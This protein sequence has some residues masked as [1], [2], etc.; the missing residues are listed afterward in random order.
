MS[1]GYGRVGFVL[2]LAAAMVAATARLDAAEAQVVTGKVSTVT[3][4][5]GQALVQRTVPVEGAVGPVEVVVT[6]LPMH[7]VPDSLFAETGDGIDVRAVRYR[8]RAVGDEP[9]EAV[10]KLDEDIER[11]EDLVARTRRMQALL[12]K[13]EAYLDK[14]EN[15]IA[16]TMKVELAKGV[17]N[18]EQVEKLSTFSFDARQKDAEESLK[19]AKEERDL[20]KELSVLKRR[21]AEL[22]R[23]S[24]RTIREALLFLQKR[25]AGNAAV[26]LSYL[27]GSAGWT[28]AYN[29]RAAANRQSVAIEYN[30]IIRQQSGEDWKDVELVLSTATPALSSQGPG[31]APFRVALRKT[32]GRQ[33][34]RG[35]VAQ[36]YKNTQMS[37]N[38]AWVQMSNTAVSRSNLDYNWAMNK[39]GN[40]GQMCE[41]QADRDA[42]RVLK[43]E[44]P[45]ELGGAS[46]SYKLTGRTSVASRSDQQM[47]RISNTTLASKFY[48]VATPVLTGYVYREA[49]LKNTAADALLGGP[50]S[51]Y[52]NGR[53]V[54][55]AE[56]P[57][58][59]SG[60]IFIIGFGAD[61]QLRATRELVDKSE[62]VQGGNREITFQ[63]RLV[64]ENYKNT[65]V[66]VRLF[67]RVPVAE[68]EDDLRLT[69]GEMKDKISA[70]KL[71]LRTERPKG[72]LRWDVD[73][74]A[75]ASGEKA[76]I[77]A[78]DYKLAFD[79]SLELH[80]PTR[81]R[82]AAMQQEFFDM[83]RGRQKR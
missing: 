49:E 61:P 64:L 45:V 22:T 31:L 83:Q 74:L 48:H 67:D 11:V 76:R 25:R 9:R 46:I 47:I 60:Q 34:A 15:F 4:Y 70:D 17:L 71:Y 3:L 80:D 77:V 6:D 59:A 40:E 2:V 12:S 63:Y 26:K 5:R 66:A 7:V 33:V 53:F 19:L 28:P 73:V 81:M 72:I 65:P 10:R 50:V 24:S 42:L 75:G 68:R 29:F 36:Q 82:A 35:Q 43:F 44:A 16:P 23:G 37:L 30:A 27:V 58:V 52:L 56:I 51:V 79:R 18:A 41:L 55:R 14:L 32:T 39:A 54:G 57:T 69:L 38:R 62:R 20:N 21:R 13:K 1:R 78:Y 8:T